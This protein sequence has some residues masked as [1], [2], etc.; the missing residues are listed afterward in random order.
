MQAQGHSVNVRD[1]MLWCRSH[2][3]SRGVVG[4]QVEDKSETQ[5]LEVQLQDESV[6]HSSRPNTCKVQGKEEKQ[7][8]TGVEH[9]S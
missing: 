8:C 1:A 3:K 2:R 5:L 9:T 6:P 4:W 7:A